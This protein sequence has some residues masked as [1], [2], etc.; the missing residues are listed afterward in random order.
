MEGLVSQLIERALEQRRAIARQVSQVLTLHDYITATLVFGSVASGA[1]DLHSDV[2]MLALCNPKLM[3]VAEREKILGQL[4][5]GWKFGCSTENALFASLDIDGSVD[6]VLVTVH[7][8]TTAW[9][10]AVLYEVLEQGAVT[11]DLLPFRPYTLP[12]LLQRAWVLSDK[13]RHVAR[14]CE[15][16]ESYPPQLKRNIVHHFVP[17][18][19]EQTA[20]LVSTARRAIGPGSFLFHLVRAEDALVSILYALNEVY[21]PADRRAEQTVWPTLAQVPMHFAARLTAILEGPF[22]RHGMI[23]R[24]EQFA[25]LAQEVLAE[26]GRVE[27]PTS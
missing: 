24:A 25:E 18:L 14:W 20:E 19:E 8:Q 13:E 11:T 3:P 22:D 21:D 17:I 10:G 6:G 12:A 9:V 4:G 15:R 2:D 26:A 7:Y 16:I 23:Q 1:V 27:Q 5:S